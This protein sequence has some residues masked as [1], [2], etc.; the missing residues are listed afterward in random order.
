MYDGVEV[1]DRVVDGRGV[2]GVLTDGTSRW[3]LHADVFVDADGL[4]AS[5]S[6]AIVAG[7]AAALDA[8][9]V[10]VGRAR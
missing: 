1:V 8:I 9:G 10:L 3:E 2:D 4:P 5:L 6:E 7:A